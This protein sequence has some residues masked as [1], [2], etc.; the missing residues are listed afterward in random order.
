M[1]Y[2][3]PDFCLCAFLGAVVRGSGFPLFKGFLEVPLFKGFKGLLLGIQSLGFRVSLR[4]A[5][6]F[7]ARV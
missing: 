4:I 3:N 1:G 5:E 6:G 2:P 7:Y